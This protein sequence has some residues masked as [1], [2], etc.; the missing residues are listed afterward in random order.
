MHG[1]L[2][3]AAARW[4]ATLARREDTLGSRSHRRAPVGRCA[5]T[6]AAGASRDAAQSLASCTLS[7]ARLR[8]TQTSY[9]PRSAIHY[10]AWKHLPLELYHSNIDL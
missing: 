9:L 6:E 10:T 7:P 3:R 4:H 5:Q 1:W 8:P 2:T